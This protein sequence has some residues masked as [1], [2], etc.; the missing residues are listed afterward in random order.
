MAGYMTFYLVLLQGRLMTDYQPPPQRNA[1]TAAD[2]SL[3]TSLEAKRIKQELAALYKKQREKRQQQQQQ[4]QQQ[5][6]SR[7]QPPSRVLSSTSLVGAA[8][9][10][11]EAAGA[12]AGEQ[13][14]GEWEEGEER[15]TT[16]QSDVCTDGDGGPKE[17][18]DD[19]EE[20]I[21]DDVFQLALAFMHDRC[22]DRLNAVALWFD[23]TPP[24][25][26]TPM[27][28]IYISPQPA[29][30]GLCP[31][32]HPHAGGAWYVRVPDRFLEQAMGFLP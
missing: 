19:E 11:A 15:P 30:R 32:A 23:S 13:E 12:G 5:S 28:N 21:D 29:H 14:E 6:Q 25:N 3:C 4:Q 20:E 17:D 7:S 27:F 22:V 18:D 16:Q 31:R 2:S 8:A 1:K 26:P 10:A 24:Q 9:A